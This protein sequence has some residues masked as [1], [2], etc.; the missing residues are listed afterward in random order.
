MVKRQDVNHIFT[1]GIRAF[2]GFVLAVSIYVFFIF[3]YWSFF[4]YD[5]AEVVVPMEVENTNN[6][7]VR[8]EP[9]RLRLDVDKRSDYRPI[10]SRNVVCGTKVFLIAP[11]FQGG[12]DA[13]P[14]GQY[15]AHTEYM[16]PKDVPANTDCTFIFINEYQVNPVRT[17]TRTWVSEKFQIIE[18]E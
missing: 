6:Q 15:E 7:V 17:I 18:G 14:Q 10:I 4:P 1:V 12:G 11:N 8:G 5:T 16:L 3:L 9:L 2:I 13:R